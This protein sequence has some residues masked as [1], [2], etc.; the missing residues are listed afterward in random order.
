MGGRPGGRGRQDGPAPRGGDRAK[1]GEHK[2]PGPSANDPAG[3][4][5]D[6]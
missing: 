3:P 6:Q 4:R 1:D 2:T 5:R